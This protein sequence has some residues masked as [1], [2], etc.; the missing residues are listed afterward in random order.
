M[1]KIKKKYE[2]DP[3]YQLMTSDYSSLQARLA[4]IDTAINEL[5]TTFQAAAQDLYNA[6]QQ[7]GAQG[8]YNPG[9]Q[10]ANPGT[11]TKGDGNDVTD[12]PF[13]EVK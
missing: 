9:A 2:P 6:Q 4:A 11:S 5:N 12:V 13:E 10:N 7:A 1:V 8:G 3:N